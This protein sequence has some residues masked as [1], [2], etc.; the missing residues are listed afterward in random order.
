MIKNLLGFWRKDLP[1][2]ITTLDI[3]E[4]LDNLYDTKGGKKANRELRELNTLFLWMLNRKL[5]FDNP[6]TPIEKYADDPFEKY[7]PPKEH[8]LT[9][10]KVANGFE[11][12]LIRTFY[13]SLARSVEIRRL[14]VADCDFSNRI[15]WFSTRK[16][17]GGSMD[18]TSL[19][20]NNSLYE[21]LYRRSKI[22]KSDYVFP[23]N[24]G[25]QLPKT[26]LDK[27]LPRIFR[28]INFTKDKAG[29]W[30]PRPEERQIKPF[31]FHSIRHHVAAHLF[32]NCGYSVADMQKILR[33][34]RASTTDTYLKSI[35]NMNLA[36]GLSA[37]DQDNFETIERPTQNTGKLIGYPESI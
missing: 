23:G 28:T 17:K 3:E 8:I 10:L 24:N 33:H 26:T 14:K 4:Y 1:L 9:A 16:R 34:K 36:K 31:G 15:V 11:K 25:G 21:I 37:L 12:D 5:I 18:R 27:I 13:H 7:V 6:M 20:M 32:L 2:P 35:I 29:R 30:R 19:E 22:A